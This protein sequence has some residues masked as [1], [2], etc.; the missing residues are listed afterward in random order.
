MTVD[1]FNREV[2]LQVHSLKLDGFDVAFRVTRSLKKSANSAEIRVYNLS[3]DHRRELQGAE[4]VPVRLQAGYRQQRASSEGTEAILEQIGVDTSSPLGVLFEGQLARAYSEREGA[5]WVTTIESDD[6]ARTLQT[7]RATLTV[8][9][10]ASLRGLLKQ[11][12]EQ[13]GIKTGNAVQQIGRLADTRL[14]YGQGLSGSAAAV[15]DRLLRE[16]DR[17]WS[18][19]G[20]LLQIVP[21]GQSVRSQAVLLSPSTGLVG[22]PT[23]EPKGIV[24]ARALLQPDLV[25]GRRVQLRS[26]TVQGYHRVYGV[27]FVG[28]SFAGDF[29]AELELQVMEP[30]AV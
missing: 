8:G 21:T 30:V 15:L 4:D 14:R 17:E 19:Q 24:K 18:V 2:R 25:P 26:S 9:R 27:E 16:H 12:A 20:G 7:G 22:T 23:K 13:T 5:D 10:N 1:L 6:D 29:Y 28:S 11:L 3:R